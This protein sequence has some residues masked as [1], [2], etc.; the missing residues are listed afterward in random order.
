MFSGLGLQV[1][2][3]IDILKCMIFDEEMKYVIL[4]KEDVLTFLSAKV[5]RAESLIASVKRHMAPLT[6]IS[7]DSQPSW[8]HIRTEAFPSSDTY[9]HVFF[10]KVFISEILEIER[11][12][13]QQLIMC[14]VNKMHE[15]PSN[16]AHRLRYFVPMAM[17]FASMDSRQWPKP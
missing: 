17:V 13:P 15:K 6:G 14:P 8:W 2:T 12:N 11:R 4:Q 1:S 16:Y 5:D 3:R 10:A 7:Y 9:V